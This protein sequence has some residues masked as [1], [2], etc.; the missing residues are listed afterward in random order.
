[1]TVG[2]I[3]EYRS[4]KSL[5]ALNKLVPHNAHLIRYSKLSTIPAALLVPGDLVRLNIGDRAPADIRL[6]TVTSLQPRRLTLV[7]R[8]GN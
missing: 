7:C 3:Q 2:F 5:A 8:L 1:M 4:E 6:V